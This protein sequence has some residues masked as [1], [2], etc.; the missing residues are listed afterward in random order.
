MN[1]LFGERARL[2]YKLP[3]QGYVR[4]CSKPSLRKFYGRYGGLIKPYE[5]PLSQLLHD[6]LGHDN[7]QW[8]LHSSGI[9]LNRDLVTELEL[10]YCFCRYNLIP[11]GFNRIFATG[12]GSQH[13]TLISLDTLSW[14][15]HLI[16]CWDHSFLNL[17]CLLNFEHSSVLDWPVH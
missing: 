6:I 9:S 16:L 2:L 12:A 7:I 10:Y 15:I 11:R 17:S 8:H 13:P 3:G 5:V 14:D 1:V 4:K